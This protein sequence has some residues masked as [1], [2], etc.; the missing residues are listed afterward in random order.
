MDKVHTVLSVSEEEVLGSMKNWESQSS[1][2]EYTS[3]N[4]MARKI[5]DFRLKVCLEYL[6]LVFIFH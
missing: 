1:F 2:E 5:V 6:I 3:S 4:V